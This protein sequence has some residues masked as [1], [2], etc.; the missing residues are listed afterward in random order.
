M[1]WLDSQLLS[2]V[3][4]SDVPGEGTKSPVCN[5]DQP[6]GQRHTRQCVQLAPLASVRA[7]DAVAVGGE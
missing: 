6:L 5:G 3:L 1:L 7:L 4:V 2:M